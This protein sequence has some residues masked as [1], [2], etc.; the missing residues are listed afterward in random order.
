MELII[1]GLTVNK[2]PQMRP[3]TFLKGK[4]NISYQSE[5]YACWQVCKSPDFYLAQALLECV[6]TYNVAIVDK[7]YYKPVVE[8]VNTAFRYL[9]SSLFYVSVS[10]ISFR[11]SIYTLS[12]SFC[13]ISAY[14]CS[15]Q[16]RQIS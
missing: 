8:N 13:T 14:R 10:S 2:T 7:K 6:V 1:P 4:P 9:P 5:D 12:S 3:F 16:Q 11:Q 15:K